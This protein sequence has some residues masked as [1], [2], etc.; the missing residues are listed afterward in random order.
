[1]ALPAATVVVPTRNRGRLIE[2]TLLSLLASA[3]AD[4]TVLVV[5]QSDNELTCDT[6]LRL[7]QDDNRLL[8]YHSATVGSSIA[9]NEGINLSRTPFVLF[10]DDDCIVTPMWVDAMVAELADPMTWAVFGAVLADERDRPAEFDD[11]PWLNVAVTQ[12]LARERYG[13]NRYDLGF[14]HGANMGFRRDALQQIGGFDPL[15]GVG[16]ALRSW[17]ERDI[18]YRIMRAGGEI[19]CT[20]RA[21]LYHRQWR[22]WPEVVKA[23]RNYG[24]GAGA[25]VNKYL[26]SGDLGSGYL[27]VEWLL[28]QGVRQVVSGVL[29]WRDHRKV[30]LGLI[31]LT[32]PW[33]GFVAGWRYAVD[34]DTCRYVHRPVR[35]PFSRKTKVPAS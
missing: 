5:D 23:H 22:N 21:R 3:R 32:Q 2:Q 14:G 25:A 35:K 11:A 20:P 12:R 15:L 29:K 31:Q 6:V 24:F 4:V 9:R 30:K 19:V 10:T 34:Y 7:A 1:M 26:R 16:G 33:L 27:L 13:K 17:P 8:Y 28:D 18:G